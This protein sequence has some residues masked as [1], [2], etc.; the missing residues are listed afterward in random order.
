MTWVLVVGKTDSLKLISENLGSGGI[1][2]L[3]NTTHQI[4]TDMPT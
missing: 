1:Y 4:Y 3:T 2:P